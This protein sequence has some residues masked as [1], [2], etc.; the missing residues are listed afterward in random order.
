MPSERNARIQRVLVIA[1]V[2]NISSAILK[3]LFGL[4]A[5]SIAMLADAV[6]SMF[7]SVS[8]VIGIYGNKLSAKPPDIEHPYG[9]SKFEQLAALGITVMI[10]VACFNILH[11]AIE[12]AIAN[13][14]PSITLYSFVSILVSLS[15]SLLISIYERR[16]GRSTS[17]IILLA[18]SSHT[19][20]DVFAS[21]V[22]I[23]G[24]FGTNMGFLYADSLAATLVC[25]ILAYVGCSLFKGA[26]SMLVD[27][28]ITSDTLMKVKA[29]VNGLSEEVKCHNVRGKT[30]GDKIY[31]DMHITVK[32]DLSVEQSHR[33]TEVIEKKLKQAIKGTEE[34]IIHVE[35]S[36]KP[37]EKQ[38]R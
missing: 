29:T 14:I 30:V 13:V 33:I 19:L 36:R 20:T 1:L 21:L 35:P 23:A 25:L 4:L 26:A 10:F 31:I 22:V 5:N 27:R 8:S 16:V 28:G 18:D 17:S 11:E 3:V 12:R 32:G 9:H 24:F 6:H 2:G 38:M 15:I 34:V 37:R 7:D